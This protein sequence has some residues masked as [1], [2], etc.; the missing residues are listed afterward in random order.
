VEM[1][2]FLNGLGGTEV[3][4][5]GG[6][7]TSQKRPIASAPSAV[8]PPAKRNRT[9]RA[10]EGLFL[11]RAGRSWN[12]FMPRDCASAN[13]PASILPTWSK[14]N[15]CS[16]SAARATRNASFLTELKPRSAGKILASARTAPGANVSDE[17]RPG[18]AS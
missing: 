8:N 5:S 14:R 18:A 15:A 9:V 3:D 4:A 2:G 11:R 17:W 7:T 12:F 6:Q 13:S 1:R 10:G 16:A